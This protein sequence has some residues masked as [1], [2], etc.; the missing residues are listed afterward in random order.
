[1]PRPP[2]H[3]TNESDHT[4]LLSGIQMLRIQEAVI[5]TTE[6]ILHLRMTPPKVRGDAI[7]WK[8]DR[9]SK[10]DLWILAS[11]ARAAWTKGIRR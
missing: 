5:E 9:L 1:M 10:E 7:R 11:T 6:M 2:V 8:R 3:K 4:G